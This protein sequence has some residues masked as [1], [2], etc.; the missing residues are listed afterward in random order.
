MTEPAHTSFLNALQRADAYPHAVE[1][2]E[3]RETHISWVFL[4][5]H[6]VYK[7]KKPVDFGF[8]D[9]S[10]LEKR[11]FFCN[12]E[13]RLNQRLAPSLYLETVPISGDINAPE[14]A[15]DGPVIEYAVKM[16]QFD[17]RQGFDELLARGELTQTHMDETAQVLAAFHASIEVAKEDSPFGTPAAIH[18]PVRENFG[19]LQ[20]CLDRQPDKQQNHLNA[21]ENWSHSHHQKLLGVF[22]ARQQQGF[23]RECHGDLHLRNI[24]IWQGK[25]TPFDGIEFSANLRWIDVM[26]ELA[27]LLMDLDDHRRHDLAQSLLNNYLEITGDYAGLTVLRYYQVYRAMVRAKVACLRLTQ[28]G[29]SD[30]SASQEIENYLQLALRY[31]RPPQAKLIIAHGLSGSG[32]TF[33]S[34]QL[35][36]HVLRHGYLI[37]LRSDVERKRLFGLAPTDK[38]QPSSKTDINTG[39]YDPQASKQTYQHLLNLT[40]QLLGQGYCVLVDAAFLKI[41]Q[42]NLFQTLAENKHIPFAIL[43]CETT[44]DIQQQRLRSRSETGADASEADLSVL[45]HQLKSVEPLTTS[46]R[47][48]S[49]T[50]DT[51]TTPKLDKIIAWLATSH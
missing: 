5:G 12:E 19:Q 7:I 39:I 36:G 28:T 29:F 13:I 40:E 50:I 10:T 47:E 21:L 44:V 11:F 42:R 16:R 49:F 9:F 6:F 23:V 2:I 33:V 26:S 35:L 30:E 51:S 32:K 18:Q 22:S 8:L 17:T 31:T 43:H 41:D 25:V 34:Q 24:V 4:T 46:E 37:R 48:S 27:F 45:Q 38:S 14:I 3:L 1:S 20:P 15:G